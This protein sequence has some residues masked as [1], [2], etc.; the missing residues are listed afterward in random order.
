MLDVC[1]VRFCLGLLLRQKRSRLARAEYREPAVAPVL[2]GMSVTV[3]NEALALAV[4][5]VQLVSAVVWVGQKLGRAGVQ[6]HMQ[7]ELS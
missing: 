5:E 3:E 6:P 1:L 2:A 7:R 4:V